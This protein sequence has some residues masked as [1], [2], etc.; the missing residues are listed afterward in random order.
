MPQAGVSRSDDGVFRR[1]R[2]V[3]S[4]ESSVPA[5]WLDTP[6]RPHRSLVALLAELDLTLSVPVSFVDHL[7][8]D[9]MS[10]FV[11]EQ[12]GRFWP[13]G[14]APVP[15]PTSCPLVH[16]TMMWTACMA[17][18]LILRACEEKRGFVV[19]LLAD[20]ADFSGGPVVLSSRPWMGPA[21]TLC[22]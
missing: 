6:H 7:W 18:A 16:G 4:L 3:L 10:N 5:A 8:T 11:A 19:T 1:E 13:C 9:A 15:E 20:E 12:P 21:V 17:D 14:D 2:P 22:S